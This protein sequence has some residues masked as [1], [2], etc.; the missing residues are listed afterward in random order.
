MTV[1]LPTAVIVEASAATV[2]VKVLPAVASKS[3]LTLALFVPAASVTVTS[4]PIPIVPAVS[5]TVT[6]S[7]VTLSTSTVNPLPALVALNCASPT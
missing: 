2:I 1:T 3:V 7:P 5:A 4:E 6:L